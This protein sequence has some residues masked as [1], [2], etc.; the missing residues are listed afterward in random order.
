MPSTSPELSK[1]PKRHLGTPGK[2]K[3][4]KPKHPSKKRRKGRG[5]TSHRKTNP[6]IGV[7]TAGSGGGLIKGEKD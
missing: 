4:E 6:P 1:K 2:E 7:K 3:K 5:Q